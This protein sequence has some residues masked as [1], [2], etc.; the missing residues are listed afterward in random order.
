MAIAVGHEPAAGYHK[1]G[2]PGIPH[3]VCRVIRRQCS[4]GVLLDLL[5]GEA[6]PCLQVKLPLL[7]VSGTLA[8]VIHPDSG[9]GKMIDPGEGGVGSRADPH[10]QSH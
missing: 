2:L 7:F 8:A 3:G 5:E 10:R 9:G 4:G 6:M 1:I